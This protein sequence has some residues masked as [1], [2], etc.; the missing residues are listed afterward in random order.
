MIRRLPGAGPSCSS[1]APRRMLPASTVPFAGLVLAHESPGAIEPGGLGEVSGAGWGADLLILPSVFLVALLYA[2]GLAVLWRRAGVG[3]GVGTW[4][5]AS[6]Y[7]GL[8]AVL[9][10]VASP[11]DTFAHALFSGHMAQHMLLVLVAAPLLVYGSPVLPLLWALSQ[12]RRV[13][14]GRWWKRA[15]APRL[16]SILTQPLVAWC[17]FALVLW[18]WHL[19]SLYQLALVSSLA[20]GFEHVTL[21]LSSCLFWWLV[22]QPVGR[23][24]MTHGSAILFVFATSLQVTLLGALISLAP[25]PLYPIYGPS[26]EQWGIQPL[27]DQ[28]LAALVMRTPMALFFLLAVAVLFLRWL[29]IM[30]LHAGGARAMRE[31]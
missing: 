31:R 30:E 7:A 21:L 2:R 6:F 12:T 27:A 25:Q 5:A 26:A 3:K 19:P 17:L 15:T 24:K 9:A 13:A 11:L 8:V 16:W 20:H 1:A 10:A 28:R 18:A 29:Q 14:A 22:I 23:R 4:Q